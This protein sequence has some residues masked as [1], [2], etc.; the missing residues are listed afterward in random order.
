MGPLFPELLLPF[1]IDKRGRRVRKCAS[2]IFDGGHALR[3]GE[4]R[5]TRSQAAQRAV[6]PRGHG[7]QFR[8]RRGIEIGT[9]K[10]RGP[11]EGALLVEDDARRDQRGPRQK[12]GQARRF[13][14]MFAERHHGFITA[15]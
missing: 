12:I 10:A 5:P 7:E 3:L 14:S 6:E 1:A 11:L 2:G 9:A 4:D 8:R 13:L 15:G